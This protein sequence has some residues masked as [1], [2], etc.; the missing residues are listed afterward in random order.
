MWKT[1]ECQATPKKAG[2]KPRTINTIK[3]GLRKPQR[4]P[5]K[6]GKLGE[7]GESKEV[8]VQQESLNFVELGETKAK[9]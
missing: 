9:K 4:K 7:D 5:K 3:E 8:D 6:P 1:K 2:V